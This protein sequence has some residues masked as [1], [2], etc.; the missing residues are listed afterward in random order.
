MN[1]LAPSAALLAGACGSATDDRPPTL[2]YITETILAPTCALAEC[3]S[4]FK[5]QVGDVFDTVE[6]TR[7]TIVLNHLVDET[8]QDSP[9]SSF[10][11][12]TLT[13]GTPSILDPSLGNIR[14]PF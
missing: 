7:R 3:H 6:S 14:M 1:R 5:Q 13:V 10:L 2:D 11:I 9:A 4:A 8:D 12:R